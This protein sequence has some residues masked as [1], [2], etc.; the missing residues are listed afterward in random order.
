MNYVHSKRVWPAS[1]EIIALLLALLIYGS[2]G[3]QTAKAANTTNPL[4]IKNVEVL[5]KG[6][7]QALYRDKV[8]EGAGTNG[9]VAG[10]YYTKYREINLKDP[11]K[12]TLEFTVQNS[13]FATTAAKYL[14]N[15]NLLYGNQPIASWGDGNTLRGTNS[16][17][18]LAD[19]AIKDNSDGTS[20]ITCT[21]ETK[22]PWASVASGTNV[23]YAGYISGG[24]GH[25]GNGQ[26]ADNRSWWE[27]GPA[28]KGP[29]MYELTARTIPAATGT[30]QADVA[31]TKLHIGPYDEMY[32]WIEM[33]N[34]SQSLIKAIT[35]KE[36]PIPALDKKPL[37]TM[38]KGYVKMDANGNFVAGEADKDVYV[39]VAIIGYGLT[40]NY[41]DNPIG[42]VKANKDFNNYSRFNAQ[43]NIVVAKNQDKVDTYLNETVPT[44]NNDPQ[45]LIDK[46]KDKAAAEID[47]MSVYYQNNTHADEVT[48]TESSIKLI[49]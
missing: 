47:F 39:E 37:G 13:S 8:Y 21:L 32:S 3:L 48:G 30:T 11:R 6:D 2:L 46:Y 4:E 9:E 20:T 45:K 28:N 36:I 35:G 18:V 19:K 22:S 33:N 29:G 31:T 16:I 27:A 23:P 26:T 5:T 1:V 43:W 38:A 44:M 34:F 7:I 12:F 15:L 42:S 24:Q 41:A 40:D 14:E 25:Y 49:K 17:F 10:K